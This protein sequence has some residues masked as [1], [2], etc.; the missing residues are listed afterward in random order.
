MVSTW[1]ENLSWNVF[2]LSKSMIGWAVSPCNHGSLKGSN[3]YLN[4]LCA[5]GGAA[6][7]ACY[8]GID[9][10]EDKSTAQELDAKGNWLFYLESATAAEDF[11][12]LLG[13]Q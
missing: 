6:M 9:V 5:A 1:P 10:S 2:L 8:I 12:K 13:A 4:S 11:G 7:T 3:S